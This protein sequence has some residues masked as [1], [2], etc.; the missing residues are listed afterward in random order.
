METPPT[1]KF[2]DLCCRPTMR[3][4]TQAWTLRFVRTMGQKH[5][6]QTL[7][8]H[9]MI[10]RKPLWSR[11]L[12]W[13]VRRIIGD[14]PR[15]HAVPPSCCNLARLVAMTPSP[16]ESMNV[17]AVRSN[18]RRVSEVKSEATAAAN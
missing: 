7:S 4:L 13:I 8:E 16:E 6:F 2:A 10:S 1:E 15:T 3:A 18:T 9:Q 12:I 11:P 17:T 14:A 5:H